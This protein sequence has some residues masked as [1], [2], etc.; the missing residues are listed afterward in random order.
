MKL[1]YRGVDYEYNPN[2]RRIKDLDAVGLYRGETVK[3]SP[4]T[5]MQPRLA[6]LKYRGASYDQ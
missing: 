1:T 6:G 3:F 5:R 4:T 2:Q